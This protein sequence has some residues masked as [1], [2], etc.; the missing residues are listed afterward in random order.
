MGDGFQMVVTP[1]EW[2]V[3][4]YCRED[5]KGISLARRRWVV[6]GGIKGVGGGRSEKFAP[7][8]MTGE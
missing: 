7:G 3:V 5:E 2:A 6:D 8:R 1:A 4:R